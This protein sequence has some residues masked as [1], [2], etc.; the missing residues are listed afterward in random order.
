IF[1]ALRAD[2]CFRRPADGSR[3][4][5]PC[6]DRMVI[7]GRIPAIIKGLIHVCWTSFKWGLLLAAIAALAAI[8]Y[9]Y[10]Q[11]NEAIRDR[12]EARIAE[13][14]PHLSVTVRSAQLIEGEGIEVRG[15]S[16]FEPGAPGPQAELL[17]V[18]ELFLFCQT[19]LKDLVQ[20][21]VD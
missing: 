16:I 13:Q 19:N 11:M 15:L 5:C 18:D 20:N 8:P 14:Y 1:E 9:F 21:K 6:H 12:V 3:A 2:W 17:Y 4:G 10:Q 7:G